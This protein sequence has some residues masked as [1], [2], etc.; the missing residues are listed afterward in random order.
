MGGRRISQPRL[1]NQHPVFAAGRWTLSLGGGVQPALV[2]QR[3]LD[4]QGGLADFL[5]LSSPYL[6]EMCPGSNDT[7]VPVGGV[8]SAAAACQPKTGAPVQPIPGA[9]HGLRLT[10]L[11]PESGISWGS[12]IGIWPSSE[13]STR[14]ASI[15]L[16]LK[17]MF[18]FYFE[19]WC[20]NYAHYTV[21]LLPLH[22]C[23][24]SCLQ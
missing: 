18:D 12:G 23:S 22:R 13:Q 8:P 6:V 21:S 1:S 20:Y 24:G 3:L 9:P 15:I 4:G 19:W 14:V 10:N 7:D 17:K 11:L 5:V 16:V 2:K